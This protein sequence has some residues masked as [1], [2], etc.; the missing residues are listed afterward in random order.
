MLV[1]VVV[2]DVAVMDVVDVVVDVAVT[3]VA[4]RVVA[5]TEV[6]VIDVAV[7][8]VEVVNDVLVGVVKVEVVVMDVVD[9]VVVVGVVVG[10][11]VSVVVG[12]VVTVV[13][14]GQIPGCSAKKRWRAR[15]SPFTVALAACSF[16]SSIKSSTAGSHSTDPLSGPLANA[17]MLPASCSHRKGSQALLPVGWNCRNLLEVLLSRRLEKQRTDEDV[18][19]EHVC[20]IV[21]R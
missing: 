13:T 3:V 1:V 16:S 15:L 18:P 10:V 19:R 4:V 21:L 8:D 7:T 14:P 2:M 11:V 12:V 6:A 9:V 5:V 17:S 20:S